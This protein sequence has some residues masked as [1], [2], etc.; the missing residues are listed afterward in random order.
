M[1]ASEERDA[2]SC[3]LRVALDK[4]GWKGMGPTSSGSTPGSY[5][6]CENW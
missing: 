4:A 6:W 2:F 1:Q 5:G 3:R